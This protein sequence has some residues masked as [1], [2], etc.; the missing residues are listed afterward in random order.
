MSS[1]PGGYAGNI[2]R[3][4]LTDGSVAVEA[5]DEAFCRKYLGGSGF[6]YYFLLK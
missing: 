1:L 3:V 2:L 6:I 5:I 4:D